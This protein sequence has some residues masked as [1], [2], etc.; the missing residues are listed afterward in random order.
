MHAPC[1]IRL[2]E[3]LHSAGLGALRNFLAALLNCQEDENSHETKFPNL[4]DLKKQLTGIF[5][6]FNYKFSSLIYFAGIKIIF[7]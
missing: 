3:W 7:E 6:F 4:E 1:P 2:S 5:H